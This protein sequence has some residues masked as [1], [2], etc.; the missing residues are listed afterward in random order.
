MPTVALKT[1]AA[2]GDKLDGHD[3]AA[4]LSDRSE[5]LT[6]GRETVDQEA[7]RGWEN[8]ILSVISYAV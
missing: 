4:G 8:Y 1:R 6:K 7:M 5:A 2:N 3:R